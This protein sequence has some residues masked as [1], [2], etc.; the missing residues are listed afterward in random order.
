MN[1]KPHC[2]IVVCVLLCLI[3]TFAQAQ[4]AK[5]GETITKVVRIKYVNPEDL[6]KALG[7]FTQVGH[8]IVVA[9][10]GLQTLTLSGSP[11]VVATMEQIVRQLDVEPPPQKPPLELRYDNVEITAYLLAASDSN[12]T[13]QKLP[14]QLE[15][16][17]KQMRSTFS[18]DSYVLLDTIVIRSR[19]GPSLEANGIVSLPVEPRR[20]ATY[21]F[22]CRPSLTHAA[23]GDML[24]LGDLTLSLL[25]G[26]DILGPD[27]KPAPGSQARGF[28]TTLDLRLGQM[29]V[30]GKTNFAVGNNALITVISARIVD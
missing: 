20:N 12:P 21:K 16:V 11:D 27:G 9:N 5:Q 24:H 29:A 7:P 22:Y 6:A 4:E 30:V 18:Y 1:R 3:T 15:P 26:G 25:I 2:W 14:V 8:A 13:G 28:N 23:N 19:V 10:R 17:I